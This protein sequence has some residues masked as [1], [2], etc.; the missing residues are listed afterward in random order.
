[1]LPF[2]FATLERRFATIRPWAKTAVGDPYNRCAICMGYTLKLTPSQDDATIEKLVGK[3]AD[4][5]KRFE[6]A[7]V[8]PGGPH[9]GALPGSGV[10]A[11]GPSQQFFIRAA[12]LQPRI[13]RAYGRPDIQGVS[14]DM[15]KSV[16]G[17][18]GVLYLENCYQTPGDIEKSFLFFQRMTGDHWD[19][20]NGINMVA[21]GY[22]L[23]GNNHAGQLYFWQ[24]R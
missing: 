9:S 19:L 10:A 3:D 5:G 21:E 17:K 12:E 20:F 13:E 24:A 6:A 16:I 4:L 14:K 8:L 22:L 1:M 11:C 15:T 23:T 2:D 7:P 18:K